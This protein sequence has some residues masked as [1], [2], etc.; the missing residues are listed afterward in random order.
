MA[1]SKT[2]RNLTVT[3]LHCHFGWERGTVKGQAKFMPKNQT[4]LAAGMW[5]SGITLAQHAGGLGFNLSVCVSLK[6][7][8][9]HSLQ[10]EEK[11][12]VTSSASLEC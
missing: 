6:V 4:L 3:K 8:L 12:V 9:T 1:M 5:C 11:E 10:P 7:A 2:Q